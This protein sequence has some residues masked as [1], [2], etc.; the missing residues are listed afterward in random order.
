[1]MAFLGGIC[2]NYESNFIYNSGPCNEKQKIM[3][4]EA[5]EYDR[6]FHRLHPDV[7]IITAVDTDHLDIY[8][9]KAEID[10]A[11]IEFVG[12]LP[13]EGF[14]VIKKGQSIEPFIS[15]VSM[16]SYSLESIFADVFC[17]RYSIN[18]GHYTF[19]LNFRGEEIKN[20]MLR[21]AGPHNIE[22]AIAAYTV[23]R[24]LGLNN[25]QICNALSS[26]KGIKRRFEKIFENERYTLIDDYAHHPEEIKAFLRGVRELYPKRKITAIFQPHL[27]SRTRDL[28]DEFAQSLSLADDVVLLEIYP[29]REQ[30]IPGVSSQLIYDR[31]NLKNKH[32]IEK[33]DLID[34]IE[35]NDTF[36]VLA[37]IGAGDIDRFLPQIS[38]LLEKK[39][40]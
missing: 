7:A 23:S 29:A 25:E 31:I 26:F 32:I 35:A 16:L 2:T 6:S 37:T 4:V 9:N 28:A 13:S 11:F 20:I 18:Q 38:L 22:N 34:W 8:G 36:E 39:V 12:L 24:Y 10:K 30:P 21:L 40:I 3:I 1:M 19:D 27:Y 14:L 33:K 17:I 5:D 15:G